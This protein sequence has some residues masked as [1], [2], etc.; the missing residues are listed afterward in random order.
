VSG[1]TQVE[2][3]FDAQLWQHDGPGGWH[4]VTLP[5]EVADELRDLAPRGRPGFGSLRVTATI[6]DSTWRTSVFPDAKSRSYVLPVKQQV[7][8]TNHLLAGD[9]VTVSLEVG[10]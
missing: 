5:L 4:F 9:V 2:V 10:A 6:G 3:T 1:Q 8:R 7:R